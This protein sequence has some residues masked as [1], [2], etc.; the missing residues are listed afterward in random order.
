MQKP[1]KFD[2]INWE[3]KRAVR[4][5][6]PIKIWYGKTQWHPKE[7]WLMRALDLDKNEKRD[8]ALKDILKFIE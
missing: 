7:Q 2:Y 5:V 1:L 6:M 3:G 4:T 8:F